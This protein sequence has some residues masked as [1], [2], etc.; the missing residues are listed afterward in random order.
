MYEDITKQILQNY[1]PLHIYLFG[2]QAKKTARPN[3]DIDLCVVMEAENKRRILADMY[4]S[5]ESEKPVDILLY[6]PSE[7][8]A[9][10]EDKTSF[11]YKINREGVKLYG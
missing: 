1:S 9:C 6:T 11:A 4:L 2:S 7:W 3:S 8:R 5:I 10:V